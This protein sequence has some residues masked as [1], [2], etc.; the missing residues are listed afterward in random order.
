MGRV[1]R[2]AATALAL[3]ILLPHAPVTSQT[4]PEPA[5]NLVR[6]RT[7]L[8]SNADAQ[9][10]TIDGATLAN[11]IVTR[12]SG[13]QSIRTVIDHNAIRIT[14]NP[15]RATF[16][17]RIDYILANVADRG[18][19]TWRLTSGAAASARLEVRNLN[20]AESRVDVFD[21]SG[22]SS[23]F[24]TD[25]ALLRRNG[26][27][28]SPRPVDSHLVLAFFYPW[29]S[30]SGWTSPLFLDQPAR[31]YSVDNPDDLARVMT[32]AKA[33]GI[34][35]LVV[36]WAGKEFAD[37]IDHRRMLACLAAGERAGI[38]IAALFEATVANPQHEDGLAD[39]D[40]VYQ[41]LADIVDSYASN[42]VYLR[43]NGR[44]VVLAYAAQ[45]MSQAG[46]AEAL[47]RLR[48]SHRDVLM[49]GEGIN[50]TRLGA[51][52][53]L[54]FYASNLYQGDE[55]FDF[56][57]IQGLSVRT[58]HLLP[59]DSGTRR[60]W[61]ATVSPGYDDT[62]LQDGRVARVTDRDNGR[63]YARQWQAALENRADWIVITT[64]NE[65]LENTEIEPGVRYDDVYVKMTKTWTLLFRRH[66]TAAR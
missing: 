66:P 30:L 24:T 45:R 37:F 2:A 42:P 36:S 39:P 41:W 28:E 48:A 47:A 29:W 51:L 43:V 11:A 58:Y 16:D 1:L 33:A 64:W 38:K 12:I 15:D 8:T 3:L 7:F 18:V 55:I 65:W 20:G 49:V 35:A 40:T 57:R 25:A 59:D 27:L 5:S 50:N 46:W 61:V 60:I 63:Y 17:L 44:P 9:E 53:G 22:T 62:H 6:T 21:A 54:F 4:L 26:P 56:D 31:L 52:D 34:D 10:L 32:Q 14:G 13:P 23:S 19:V